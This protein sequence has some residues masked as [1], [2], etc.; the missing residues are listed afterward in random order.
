MKKVLTDIKE[1]MRRET[2]HIPRWET[3]YVKAEKLTVLL[4]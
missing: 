4:E 2:H 3:K 1:S